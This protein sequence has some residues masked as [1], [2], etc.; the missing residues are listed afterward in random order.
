MAKFFHGWLVVWAAHLLL[1]IAFGIA[2]S[3][4]TLFSHLQSEFSANRAW[5]ASI[6]SAAAFLYYTIGAWAGYLSDKIPPRGLVAA[7]VISLGLGL[8]GS[9]FGN[10]LGSI[11]FI[12]GLGIGI[13]VGLIYTPA[14]R[15]VQA[16]FVN[17]R[18][19]ATGLAVTGTGLGTLLAPILTSCLLSHYSWREVL[20]LLALGV[21]IIG[22][23][24][25]YFIESDPRKRGCFPDGIPS[26]TTRI[27][28]DRSLTS[29]T[30][31]QAIRLK[32]FWLLYA[33][34]LL[35]SVGL[36]VPFVHMVPYVRDIGLPET[37]GAMLVGLIG[38]G[39][40][41]GRFGLSRLADRIGRHHALTL[42]TI[43]MAASLLFWLVA[44]DIP[45]LV[46]FSLIFGAMYGS[47]VA[48]YPTVA[49]DRFG[50]R[51]SGAIIGFLYTGVG[52]AAVVGP[53]I[54]G[55]FFD[56][57]HSYHYPI[58]GS[59][60]LCGCSAWLNVKMNMLDT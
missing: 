35:A 36:F 60:V 24:S 10:S 59:A 7:G 31:K 33:V 3:F 50:A 14:V 17:L 49:T 11:I 8:A 19:R 55:L 51:H 16:W 6:F 52:I 30:L 46:V 9:S 15:S 34:I 12:Y 40:I 39:N 27:D 21:V 20:R 44:G 48:L 43:G 37:T 41:L 32:S 1:A 22:L 53:P 42:F 2:Y 58:L 54:A 28:S 25:A 4:T 23:P 57:T 26:R 56:Q 18:G 29:V 45:G 5:I 47:C 38:V 13:G